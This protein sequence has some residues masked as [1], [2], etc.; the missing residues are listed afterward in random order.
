MRWRP[1]RSP[2][3]TGGTTPPRPGTGSPRSG[4]LNGA[5]PVRAGRRPGDGLPAR[6]TA[7]PQ[8]SP[9]S[10]GGTTPGAPVGESFRVTASTEP[11]Q[12]GRDDRLEVGCLDAGV[13]AST[14]PAQYGRDDS[15]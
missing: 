2:P 14:E 3:S 5:R 10:T 6:G 7:K 4:R 12:Y 9:P 13:N 15:A 1:Q 11:A 8:R